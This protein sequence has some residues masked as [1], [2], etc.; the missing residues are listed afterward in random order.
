VRGLVPFRH[1]L[2]ARERAGTRPR[3]GR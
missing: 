1:V 2:L 3:P